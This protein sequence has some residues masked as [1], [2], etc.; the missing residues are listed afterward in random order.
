MKQIIQNLG[1]TIFILAIILLVISLMQESM[2]NTLLLISG[3]MI[4]VGLF[5]HVI[6]NK[7]QM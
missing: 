2:N 5:V 7:K 3:I 6:V 1:L 4:V